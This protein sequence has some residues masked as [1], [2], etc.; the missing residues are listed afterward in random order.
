MR[1]D[2]V[3]GAESKYDYTILLRARGLSILLDSL[4][5]AFV[6]VKSGDLLAHLTQTCHNTSKIRTCLA[7]GAVGHC[8]CD[9]HHL[10]QQILRPCMCLI[11]TLHR[12]AWAVT[13]RCVQCNTRDLDSSLIANRPHIIQQSTL[14]LFQGLEDTILDEFTTDRRQSTTSKQR[15]RGQSWI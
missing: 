2:P 7:P 14:V 5:I 8:Q 3:P 15:L 10:P 4:N 11:P 9:C 13:H 6:P 12:P 1:N